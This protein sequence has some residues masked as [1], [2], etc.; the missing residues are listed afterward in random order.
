[1]APEEQHLRLAADLYTH[2]PAHTCVHLHI[3]VCTYMCAHTN[4]KINKDGTSAAT[5][6]QTLAESQNRRPCNLME[7]H[8]PA[9]GAWTHDPVLCPFTPP[10]TNLKKQGARQW[11]I[12]PLIPALGRQRQADL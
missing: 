4:Y 10:F 9:L 1:M 3:H 8:P 7:S 11:W 2:A 5:Q 6:Q 12:M